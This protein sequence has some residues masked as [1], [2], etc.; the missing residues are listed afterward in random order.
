MD[1]SD[2]TLLAT[3][4]SHEPL[5][6]ALKRA[7]NNIDLIRARTLVEAAQLDETDIF[8]I[9][10]HSIV[11]AEDAINFTS[12]WAEEINAYTQRLQQKEA[13]ELR[14]ILQ[15]EVAA[16]EQQ[17][18][19]TNIE[20]LEFS[21]KNNYLGGAAQI[22]SSLEKLSQ[23][24]LELEKA[25]ATA[26]AKQQQLKNQTE[27]IKRQSPIDLQLKVSKEEL[28]NLRS[29]YT[30]A[31]PLVQAKLQSIEYLNNQVSIL[32][33]NNDA[34]PGS[35][36]GTP[37]G[38][39]LYISILELRN[40]LAAADTQISSLEKL[41]K[42]ASE[43]IANMPAIISA[44]EALLDQ[45][46]TISET[47]SLM[48]NRLKE[49]E[50]FA[51][52]APGYWQVFQAPDPRNIIPSSLI[53]KPL[54]LG[55][56]CGIA[57]T[58]IAVLL[59]VLLTQRSSR[60]SILE[61]CAATGAPLLAQFY[62]P[63]EEDDTELITNFWITHFSPQLRKPQHIL[64]WTSA[65]DPAD[66]RRFWTLLATVASKDSGKTIRVHDL[67]ADALWDD[68]EMPES[69]IWTNGCPQEKIQ[70]NPIIVRASAPPSGP[71]RELL[72]EVDYWITLVSG[73]A[74]SLR[75]VAKH[76]PFTDSCLPPCNGTIGW[77]KAT[78]DPIRQA[79][80][81]ISFFLAT[82]FS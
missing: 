74:S 41:Y 39:E 45:R 77:I 40:E 63:A 7:N 58:G 12:I 1:F 26:V 11:S 38:N 6:N 22:A 82:R 25:R 29:T 66:E 30:D 75:L 23:I 73:Q 24:E 78:S 3:L 36:T 70:S 56:L 79:A 4:L 17:L 68:C 43:R 59:T 10:Y 71:E 54:I 5:D 16:L 35:Y 80:D 44:H 46:N 34:D 55:A 52:G 47:H 20:L 33:E 32:K 28:A 15:K 76:R 65:I 42:N 8:F 31:N 69:L 21:K 72:F 50:I 57:G 48:S 19:R 64:F 13:H 14:L 37:I 67:T 49:A 60:R 81:S 61:C 53:K 27:Q 51:S 9:T 62:T 18:I 2:A